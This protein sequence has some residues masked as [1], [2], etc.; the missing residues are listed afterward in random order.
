M[1]KKILATACLL[2]SVS[3][4]ANELDNLVN[5]S[6]TIASKLDLGI[7]YVGAATV[8]RLQQVLVSQSLVYRQT[9][10]FQQQK[11]RLT[12]APFK[13]WQALQLTL[14]LSF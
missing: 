7:Q 10:T 1:N 12:I 14:L 2:A 8:M 6:S 5:A 9:L 3:A 13:E 4:P 11:Q